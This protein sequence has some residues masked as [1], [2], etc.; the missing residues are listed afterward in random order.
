MRDYGSM[1]AG[2]IADRR[3][4]FFVAHNPLEFEVDAHF[5]RV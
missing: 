3:V 5:L 4:A 2:Q 1:V